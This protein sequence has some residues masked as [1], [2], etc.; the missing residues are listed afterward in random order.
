MEKTVQILLFFI[1]STFSF[2]SN[3]FKEFSERELKEEW[4]ISGFNPWFFR[5]HMKQCHI[6]NLDTRENSFSACMMAFHYL[7]SSI[8]KNNPMQI[9]VSPSNKL[10]IAPYPDGEIPETPGDDSWNKRRESF[11]AFF[12]S[13]TEEGSND[14]FASVEKELDDILEESLNLLV[15]RIPHEDQ[16]YYL[17]MSFSQYLK[18]TYSDPYA[19]VYPRRLSE[20]IRSSKH[21]GIGITL[22]PYKTEDESF[23]GLLVINP[24]E[25]SPAKAA[26]LKKGDILLAVNGVSVKGRSL[27]EIR[28]QIQPLE[29]EPV[30]LT[31]QSFCDGGKKDVTIINKQSIYAHDIIEDSRFINVHQPEPLD[32]ND[33]AS[34]NEK[35]FQ[36]LYVPIKNF[37]SPLVQDQGSSPFIDD[38]IFC[39]KFV[40]LQKKDLDNE[41]SLGM[42]IDLRGNFGGNFH[43]ASCIL[44]TLI[45]D[46]DVIFSEVPVEAGRIV[47]DLPVHRSYFTSAGPI[48]LEIEGPSTITPISYNKNI[49]VLVDDSSTSAA[50]IFAGVIQDKKR[51]WIVGDRTMGKS[52]SYK[53]TLNEYS[54]LMSTKRPPFNVNQTVATYTL[55]S[56]RSIQGVGVV[57]DFRF[58]NTGEPIEDDPF[59]MKNK[60]HFR[61]I[62][63]GHPM[64]TKSS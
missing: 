54:F 61:N 2:P 30:R 27:P 43:G 64:G 16:A 53:T 39:K 45:S 10:E 4:N 17:G 44:N 58:S 59:S 6:S 24:F 12:L 26:G 25:G 50:E 57:P 40:Q 8:T 32:C 41:K 62:K 18:E 22:T 51:G 49:V 48:N 56:G 19:M 60:L 31:I 15:N 9:Q 21:T 23:N 37:L 14:Q 5:V 1:I 3:S 35:Q 28:N 42:I 20:K 36:A 11:I 47:N 63:L 52:S 29:D 13:R 7:V 33:P 55:S 34:F 46:T 38:L